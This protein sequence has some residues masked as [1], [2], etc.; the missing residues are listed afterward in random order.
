[1]S[2]HCVG[3][4]LCHGL[5]H[6]KAL[7]LAQKRAEVYVPFM[8]VIKLEERDMA[9]TTLFGINGVGKRYGNF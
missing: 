7:S 6:W 2:R 9:I 1:M 4:F 8:A 5:F 3:S